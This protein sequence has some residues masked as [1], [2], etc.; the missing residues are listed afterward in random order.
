VSL[1]SITTHDEFVRD[2]VVECNASRT[3]GRA[4]PSLA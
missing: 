2:A 1:V 4:G 3:E